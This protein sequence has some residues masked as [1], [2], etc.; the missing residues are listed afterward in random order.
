MFRSRGTEFE[1]AWEQP[2]WW[3]SLS[4]AGWGILFLAVFATA[5]FICG[6]TLQV[7]PFLFSL[8]QKS[9]PAV[10]AYEAEPIEFIFLM[11]L[12]FLLASGLWWLFTSWLRERRSNAVQSPASRR[13]LRR[14]KH[15]KR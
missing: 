15:D 13:V 11:L 9:G 7:V 1:V 10:A 8:R 4:L 5:S 2:P 14:E 12:N 3:R 6:A